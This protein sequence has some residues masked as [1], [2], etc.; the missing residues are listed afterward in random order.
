MTLR[1][2]AIER[3]AKAAYDAGNDGISIPNWEDLD[4]DDYRAMMWID[5]QRT[6]LDALLALLAERGAKVV[7][8][9]TA[10][11]IHNGARD[12]AIQRYGVGV[13]FDA[14]RSC[15]AAML[16]AAPDML[17]DAK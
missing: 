15:Y 11:E 16:A 1:D 17:G 3:M 4:K 10:D 5:P 14:S 8:V 2:D 7:P 9:V 12:W 13:G 6:A